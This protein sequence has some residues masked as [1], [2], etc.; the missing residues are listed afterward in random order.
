MT[1]LTRIA[2]SAAAALICAAAGVAPAGA[3]PGAWPEGAYLTLAPIDAPV[4]VLDAVASAHIEAEI[5][6]RTRADGLDLWL[7]AEIDITDLIAKGAQAL[8][9]RWID[10]KCAD[11]L[12]LSDASA[13]PNPAGDALRVDF[14]IRYKLNQCVLG[15]SA[16]FRAGGRAAVD[17]SIETRDGRPIL[18]GEV[19]EERLDPEIEL[20]GVLSVGGLDEGDARDLLI[21][22]LT[23]LLDREIEKANREGLEAFD[24][25]PVA[26]WIDGVALEADPSGGLRLAV[27]ASA[28][29]DPAEI[30][31][32]IRAAIEGGAF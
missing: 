23:T 11:Q 27:A 4:R 29:A 13:A 26:I 5:A 9:R 10:D 14:E 7:N 18:I 16:V 22:V 32:L 19:V 2:K 17:L 15:R 20:L 6:L 12:T 31:A 30:D 1:R 24:N 25:A 21:R 8:E 28:S 3:E